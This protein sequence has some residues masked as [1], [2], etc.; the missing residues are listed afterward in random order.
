MATMII[1]DDAL[2]ARHIE[3]DAALAQRIRALPADDAI[4]LRIE[5]RPIRFRKMRDGRDG[6]PTDGVRPDPDFAE[7]WRALQRRRGTMVTIEPE[8]GAID[9]YLLSLMATLTEWNSPE[10]AAAYDGL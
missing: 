6:R 10:D 4:V 7:F 2:W 3:G 5:G 9:P 8:T 1:R